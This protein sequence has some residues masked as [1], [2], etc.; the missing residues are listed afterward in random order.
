MTLASVPSIAAWRRAF[1]QFGAKPTQHRN[2][3]EALLRRLDK[4]GEIPSISTLVDIGNLISIRYAIP[5]AINR[6]RQPISLP[7][8]KATKRDGPSTRTPVTSC[9]AR[10]STPNR[11]A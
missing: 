2:A 6:A 7:F 10:I 3:A 8:P 9:G 4:Q 1:S 5:V 11:R